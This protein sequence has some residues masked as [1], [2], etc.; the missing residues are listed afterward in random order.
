MY[1]FRVGLLLRAL[2]IVVIGTVSL[3]AVAQSPYRFA[4]S[5]DYRL[6]IDFQPAAATTLLLADRPYAASIEQAARRENL[7]PFLVHALIHVESNHNPNAVSPKGAVGLMQVLPE[8]AERFGSHYK[9]TNVDDNLRAGTHYLK[10]LI[11]RFDQRLDLALAA[12][13]AGEN[14]VENHG[15]R[16]PPYA[17]T[18]RYV[19]AV[20]KRYADWKTPRTPAHTAYLPGTQL[21]P[22]W[23]QRVIAP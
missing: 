3:Q 20:L 8:T 23:E 4:T 19:P 16:I 7:D 13:N 15:R 5:A 10:M 9:L 14:A 6:A 12:Y 21:T 18:R 17:E 11:D 2:Q 1:R 22:A